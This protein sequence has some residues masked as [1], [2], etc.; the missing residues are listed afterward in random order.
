[1]NVDSV[2]VSWDTTSGATE[3]AG[4]NASAWRFTDQGHMSSPTRLWRYLYTAIRCNPSF[5]NSG[6]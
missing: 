1:M 5:W 4:V 2:A 6:P 3:L